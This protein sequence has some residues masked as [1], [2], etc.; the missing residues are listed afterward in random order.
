MAGLQDKQMRHA[1]LRDAGIDPARSG[2]AEDVAAASP[3]HTADCPAAPSPNRPRGT[4]RRTPAGVGA[5]GLRGLRHFR[6]GSRV[7]G[8]QVTIPGNTTNKSST[9]SWIRKKG[10]IPR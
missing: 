5:R 8:S 1:K 10:T 4:S 3:S 2:K 7:S 6:L 9:A